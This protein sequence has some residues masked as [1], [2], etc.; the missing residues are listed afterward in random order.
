MSAALRVVLDEQHLQLVAEQRAEIAKLRGQMCLGIVEGILANNSR[1]RDLVRAQ[2]VD[3][4]AVCEF[5]V[6]IGYDILFPTYDRARQE[7]SIVDVINWL[8][9]QG[10]KVC[11][12]FEVG[13][14]VF[15]IVDGE[16]RKVFEMTDRTYLRRFPYTVHTRDETRNVNPEA[17]DE[18]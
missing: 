13:I 8:C 16:D 2:G 3:A 4:A 10:H 9:D 17:T 5:A 11:K 7:R 12:W 1:Y 6:Y 15:R 14:I 18:L